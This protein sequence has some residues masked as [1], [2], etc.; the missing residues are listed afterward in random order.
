[1]EDA[2]VRRLVELE[3]HAHPA[4]ERPALLGGVLLDHGRELLAQRGVVL[5]DPLEVGRAELDDVLVGDQHRVLPDDGALV[6]GLA[7]QGSGDLD[8]LDMGA[9]DTG[10]PA[11]H[12][13]L[14]LALE[15]LQHSHETGPFPPAGDRIRAPGWARTQC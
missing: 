10:E 14:E 4:D 1:V 15:A 6:G 13:A 9:E 5:P 12:Q 11:L 7:L 2:G 8:G 3:L